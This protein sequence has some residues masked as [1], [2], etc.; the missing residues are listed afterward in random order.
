M[1]STNLMTYKIGYNE[2]V[3]ENEELREK[4]EV[5]ESEKRERG[6]NNADP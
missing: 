5:L 4:I 3:R 1:M 2:I 6:C